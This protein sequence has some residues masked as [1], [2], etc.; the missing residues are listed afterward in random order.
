MA[1]LVALCLDPLGVEVVQASSLAGAVDTARHELV[2]LILLDLALGTEDGLEIL[3][4]LRAEP[5]L[6]GVPIVAFS[7]HDSRRRESLDRG[8]DSF[9]GRPFS[10][11]DLQSEVERHLRSE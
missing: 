11:A 3:P 10:S 5:A 1:S 8:V 7:A 9:V 6:A 2:N 4:F